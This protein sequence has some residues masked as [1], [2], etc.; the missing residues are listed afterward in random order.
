[1]KPV[2]F[3]L[4]RYYRQV[5][6]AFKGHLRLLPF[7]SRKVSLEIECSELLPRDMHTSWLHKLSWDK[8]CTTCL[9]LAHGTAH[10][11][12]GFQT[13]ALASPSIGS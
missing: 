12:S 10:M 8:A 1:M 3:I 9:K 4:I 5:R 7:M 2:I 13:V 6:P 11:Q